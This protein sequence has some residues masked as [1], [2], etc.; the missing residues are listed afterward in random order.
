VTIGTAHAVP[1]RAAERGGDA[2][3]GPALRGAP[4]PRVVR[5]T[6]GAP[7]A[8]ND[9]SVRAASSSSPARI[10]RPGP[11]IVRL[12]RLERAAADPL[13]AVA[14]RAVRTSRRAREHP[15]LPCR[16]SSRAVLAALG[17]DECGRPLRAARAR[18]APSRTPR[19][20]SRRAHLPPFA[21]PRCSVLA[22]GSA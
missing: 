10:S 16:R 1:A 12:D 14:E 5:R 22:G 9:S 13:A 18:G 6:P 2:P 21:R 19:T 11:R 17:Y 20:L 7:S 4:R 3:A 8:M 15:R